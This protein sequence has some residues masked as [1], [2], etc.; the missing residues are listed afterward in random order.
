MSLFF[1]VGD[2]V[3]SCHLF[4]V[5]NVITLKVVML[6]INLPQIKFDMDS[7]T[8]FLNSGARDPSLIECA[9]WWSV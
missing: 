7:V 2:A 6:K 5:F 3:S 8:D 4:I 9:P 1:S